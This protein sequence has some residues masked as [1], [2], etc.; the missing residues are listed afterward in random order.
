MSNLNHAKQPLTSAGIPNIVVVRNGSWWYG[1]D[2][3]FTANA[4]ATDSSGAMYVTGAIDLFGV[5]VGYFA[6]FPA[7]SSIPSWNHTFGSPGPIGAVEGRAIAI[8][9]D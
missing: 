1:G 8:D 4:I 5:D 9:R 2:L 7:G 6:K 3:N